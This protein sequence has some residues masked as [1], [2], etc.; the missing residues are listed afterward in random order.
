MELSPDMEGIIL[1]ER[2]YDLTALSRKYEA[3]EKDTDRKDMGFLCEDDNYT[4]TLM[5]IIIMFV[6]PP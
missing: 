1:W 5:I 6:L 2:F 3:K 4:L